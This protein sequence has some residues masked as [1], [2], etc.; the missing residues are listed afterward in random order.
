MLLILNAK[1]P[2]PAEPRQKLKLIIL[3]IIVIFFQNCSE[4]PTE[5]SENSNS[6]IVYIF[7]RHS[8]RYFD[9]NLWDYI[10]E[11]NTRIYGRVDSE[12][13]SIFEYLKINNNKY[14]ANEICEDELGYTTFGYD[15]DKK[16]MLKSNFDTLHIELKTD[17]GIIEGEIILPVKSE[18]IIVNTGDSL[19]L[20]QPFSFSWEDSGADFYFVS[21]RYE[22]ND[23]NIRRHYLDLE[24]VISTN[25]IT[26]PDYVFKYH[27]KITSIIVKSINGPIPIEKAKGNMNGYGVGFLY[28]ENEDYY[29]QTNIIVGDGYFGTNKNI[30]SSLDKNLTNFALEKLIMQFYN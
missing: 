21:C 8:D 7:A 28:Y 13:I 20:N 4:N 9:P 19:Q 5:N 6:Q 10:D 2:I 18:N 15:F 25:Q 16:M 22:W 27:G 24:E 30:M 3:L 11:Q 14:Y 12:P 26:Y 17:N 23:E 29:L 1:S